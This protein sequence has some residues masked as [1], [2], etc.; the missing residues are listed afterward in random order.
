MNHFSSQKADCLVVGQG[1][2]RVAPF[3]ESSLFFTISAEQTAGKKNIFLRNTFIKLPIN[4]L[5]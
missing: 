3:G 4:R 5:G 2:I 1:E